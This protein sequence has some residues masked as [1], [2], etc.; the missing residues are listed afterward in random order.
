MCYYGYLWYHIFFPFFTLSLVIA[1][2]GQSC[3]S[4]AQDIFQTYFGNDPYDENAWAKYRREILEYG[5][6][7]ANEMQMLM[8]YLGRRPDVNA[9]VEGLKEGKLGTYQSG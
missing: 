6:S 7:H 3:T 1:D 2:P 4:I 9:L 8:D 5:G